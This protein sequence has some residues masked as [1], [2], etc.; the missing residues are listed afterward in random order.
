MPRSYG[1]HPRRDEIVFSCY[2]SYSFQQEIVHD[3]ILTRIVRM[4]TF[5][6]LRLERTEEH[7]E[8]ERTV[9]EP[10]SDKKLEWG[11]K[12]ALSANDHRDTQA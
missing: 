1:R 3:V 10:V 4:R 12:W 9:V 2:A 7:C 6:D 11:R 5:C 8:V